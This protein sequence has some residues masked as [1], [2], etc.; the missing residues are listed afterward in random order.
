MA[1][2]IVVTLEKDLAA[3]DAAAYAKAKSGKALA[4]ESDRLDSAARRRGVSPPT[5]LLSENQAVLRAQMEANGFDP[6]KMRLPAELWFSAAEGLKSARAL[7]EYI[8]GNM[9]DFKQPNAILRDLKAVEAILTAADAA[10]V[11]FH[12]TRVEL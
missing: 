9:N 3:A 6:S 5:S 4:R 8:T 11:K 2:A 12:F 10:G 7:A 1:Q